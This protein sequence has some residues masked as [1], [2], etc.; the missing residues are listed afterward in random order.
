VTR[1]SYHIS[2]EQFAP[3]DLLGL[4]QLAEQAGFDAAFT[5]DHMHPWS[6]SQGQSGFTWAWLGAALAVTER[7]TFGAITVPG[8]WRYHPA[9]LAQAIATLGQMFPGRVPWIALGS[10]QALN[11]H[12]AGLPW[13]EKMERNARL[14]EG[15]DIIRALLAG[16]TVTHRGRL[17]TVEAKVWS[18]PG[19]P[20]QLVGAATS[21]A[22]AECVGGWA[23]GL[24]TVRASPERLLRVV[25]AFRRG[26]GTGKPL[27]LKVDLSWARR[28]E[29]ALR[30]AHEQWR[31]N[32]LGND[33]NWD[34]RR[35]EDFVAATRF[36][37]PEDM[38]ENVLVSDDL[39]RFADWI[40]EY[41]EMG[42]ESIDLHNVG[43]NQ[44]EFVEMFGTYVLPQLRD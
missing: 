31:F 29:Q 20:T 17:T 33:A 12:V 10:G 38:R 5:S 27:H 43:A 30:Q 15:A 11:E 25:D 7:L 14:R 40:S 36:V 22:T 13:P 23:D 24:L 32:I 19:T 28:E 6:P 3:K 26:G 18:R 42:F 34:L 21:E 2:H 39:G 16:E 37:R 35:P 9:V 44:A 1:F 4:V 8:G 41:M